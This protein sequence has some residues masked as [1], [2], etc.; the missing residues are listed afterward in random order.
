MMT[1]SAADTTS[2]ESIFDDSLHGQSEVTDDASIRNADP[3]GT[4]DGKWNNVY[5]VPEVYGVYTGSKTASLHDISNSEN[6]GSTTE[7]ITNDEN[8]HSV[9]VTGMDVGNGKDDTVAS[10]AYHYDADNPDDSGLELSLA[11]PTNSYGKV[12]DD[13]KICSQGYCFGKDINV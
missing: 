2:P 11:C 10:I 13:F 12:S 4:A 6:T 5:T 8:N 9:A 1:A 3:Y 7:G